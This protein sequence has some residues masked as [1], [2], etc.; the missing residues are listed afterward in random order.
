MC[1]C[2]CVD[3]IQR[4][5]IK[6]KRTSTSR[7]FVTPITLQRH[8]SKESRLKVRYKR[9]SIRQLIWSFME[10]RKLPSTFFSLFLL[11]R[12][13]RCVFFFMSLASFIADK[14]GTR[15]QIFVTF[16]TVFMQSFTHT[17]T[18]HSSRNRYGLS[19]KSVWF[20][21]CIPLVSF[22][23]SALYCLGMHLFLYTTTAFYILFMYK[24]VAYSILQQFRLWRM[25]VQLNCSLVHQV[26]HLLQC[27]FIRKAL[28][29][30]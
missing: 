12:F 26:A 22:T 5:L 4:L 29:M 7:F 17:H 16:Y 27:Y 3:A 18:F 6:Q 8:S 10:K 2:V 11:E 15:A 13:S 19:Y 30:R 9:F 20:L 24:T 1:M 21:F 25:F 28:A 14:L 23:H